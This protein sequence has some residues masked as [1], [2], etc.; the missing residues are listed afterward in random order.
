MSRRVVSLLSG[1][2]AL[3]LPARVA[4]WY[5]VVRG[6]FIVFHPGAM[7]PESSGSIH[8]WSV[9]YQWWRG[10]RGEQKERSGT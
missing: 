3:G 7:R 2:N 8:I 6:L 5:G 10:Q 9:S 4:G 1:G